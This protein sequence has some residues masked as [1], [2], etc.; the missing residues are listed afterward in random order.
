MDRLSG[1]ELKC[2]SFFVYIYLDSGCQLAPNHVGVLR[3][4]AVSSVHNSVSFQQNDRKIR[5][6]LP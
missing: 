5:V 1:K 2:W 4:L 6:D 3:C